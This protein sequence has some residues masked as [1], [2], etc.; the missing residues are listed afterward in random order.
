MKSL[1][2]AVA[3]VALTASSAFAQLAPVKAGV[4]RW[5]GTRSVGA[6]KGRTERL[7]LAG[8]TLDLDVLEVRAITI[9]ST[10][11][12]DTSAAQDSLESFVLVKEGKL[13]A[14][15]NGVTRSL[16]AGGVALV[17]P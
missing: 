6:P 10:A 7:V 9:P 5:A 1:L 12:I 16:G 8:S 13:G 2:V 11:A 3:A 15:L 14:T 17:L 4:Y